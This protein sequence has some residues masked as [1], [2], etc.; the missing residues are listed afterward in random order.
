VPHCCIGGPYCS[1]VCCEGVRVFCC[2]LELLY[3]RKEG[4]REGDP[5][6]TVLAKWQFSSQAAVSEALVKK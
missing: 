6:T 2:A 4:G 5:L 3:G 1:A